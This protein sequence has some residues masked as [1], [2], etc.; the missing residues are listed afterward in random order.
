MLLLITELTGISNSSYALADDG[1]ND[2]PRG[3]VNCEYPGNCCRYLDTNNDGICDNSQSAPQERSETL[4][5]D[6]EVTENYRI[7]QD[8][9]AADDSESSDIGN[10]AGNR[11][12]GYYL[13]PNLLL[14]GIL[15]GL[16]Y[17]LSAIR[18]IRPVVHRKIWN[19]MLLVTTVI[20]AVLGL[21]L[22]LK[23]D[24]K[25]NVSLPFDILFWHV[26]AGIA[27]G[28]IAVFHILWHWRY[29]QTML[30]SAD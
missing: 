11:K 1:W 13:I 8:I 20:S 23:I 18:I 19:L 7:N 28:M 10:N 17:L 9:V 5:R 25:V 16:S 29:F 30:T 12:A 6:L 21:I 24:F 26:E 15:Y 2:C 3:E 4:V 27:M 14:V 22:I